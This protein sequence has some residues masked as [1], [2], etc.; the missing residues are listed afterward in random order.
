MYYADLGDVERSLGAF[1][2]LLDRHPRRHAEVAELF[3]RA[4]RTRAAIDA[5]SGFAEALMQRC[6]ELFSLAQGLG[7]LP[8]DPSADQDARRNRAGDSEV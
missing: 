6:P 7:E 3:L 2:T 5:Q 1:R 4:V 8:L